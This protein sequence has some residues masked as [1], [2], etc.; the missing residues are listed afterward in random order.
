VNW[1]AVP[2]AGTVLGLR[3][4]TGTVRLFGRGAAAAMLWLVCWYYLL[5]A[6]TQR[7][8]SRDF[9]RRLNLPTTPRALHR[10]LWLFARVALDRLLFLTG[11]T[12]D[13]VVN[14]HGHEHVMAL[15]A[16]KTGGLLVGAHLGSFEAMRSL[17]AQ[18]DVPL[19]V[20]VDFKNAERVNAVLERLAPDL[21]VRLLQVDPEAPTGL[22]AA[23]D[24]IDRGELVAVLAD[25]ATGRETR[26]LVVPFLG[27]QARLPVGVHL[28]ASVL[29]CP[30][31]FVCALFDGQRTYDVHCV[32][33]VDRVVLPRKGRA[34]AL[35]AEVERYARV[36][37]DFTRRSPH[38]WFNFFP[39][40]VDS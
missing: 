24:A 27:G 4:V 5:V 19:L 40:W 32:P 33:L 38:N 10:H 13:L 31:F 25:R 9:F 7:N 39:F 6:T 17:A 22:L 26:D 12:G 34:D 35:R 36:L 21:R 37:E 3:L 20:V 28:L 23:K 18:Y 16:A 8:A 15:A 14:L 2:E 1:R 30:V 29:Q 11:R